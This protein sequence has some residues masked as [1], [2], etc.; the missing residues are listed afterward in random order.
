MH[1]RHDDIEHIRRLKYKYVRLLDTGQIEAM[2]ELFTEDA[3]ALYVG[4][5]F[6]FE[7]ESRASLLKFFLDAFT[8]DAIS[9]H[10][11]NHP[12]IDVLS[13]SQATG[14]WYLSDYYVDLKTK[15]ATNGAALY[16]DRYRKENGVWRISHTGYERVYEVV[17]QLETLP[18]LTAHYLGKVK[19]SAKD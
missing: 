18:N 8:F 11:V 6:R 12:E 1:M 5:S 17:T 15:K 10:Q 3:T 16:H 13:D 14:I 7:I 9:H 2:G 19:A 4:G